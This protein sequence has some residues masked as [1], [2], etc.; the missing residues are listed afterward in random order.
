MKFEIKKVALSSPSPGLNVLAL[1]ANESTDYRKQFSKMEK[2]TA[3]ALIGELGRV[4]FK[5]TLWDRHNVQ[6]HGG[7]KS[8]TIRLSC[9]SKE[10]FS[11]KAELDSWRRLAGDAVS[12]AKALS[13]TEIHIPLHS[14]QIEILPRVISCVVEGASLAA[15]EFTA[16]KSKKKDISKFKVTIGLPTAP[17]NAHRQALKTGTVIASAVSAARNMVNT[18]PSDLPPREVVRL[19]K[20]IRLTSRDSIKVYNRSALKKMGAGALLGVSAGSDEEPFLVHMNIKPKKRTKNSRTITLIGKGVTFDSGGLSIKPG[21]GM[22]DMKCDMAGAAAVFSTAQ[23]LLA[24]RAELGLEHDVHIIAPITENMI[25][26]R[27]TKPGDVL[28]T[29][30]GKTIEVLNTDAEGRL[31]LADALGYAEKKIKSDVIIDLATLTGACIV[32]I[33]DRYSGLFSDSE[34]QIKKLTAAGT[35]AGEKLWR[36]PIAAEYRPQMDSDV[37]DIKN[38]GSGGPGA[39]IGALFLKDFVPKGVE[40]VHLDIAGPAFVTYAGDYHKKGATGVGV[41]TLL[42]YLL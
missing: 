18:P 26:G 19:A 9:I 25:N 20:K 39:T 42:E 17:T 6:I 14:V 11:D 41:R 36:L 24:L 33:G 16:F 29:I 28:R 21:K 37:A 8:L 31:I 40:W 15:Y 34:N 22:E 23:A 35:V 3:H 13:L 4:K 2:E 1:A 7:A 32:A 30:S 12:N 27:A 5:A 10:A 38:I